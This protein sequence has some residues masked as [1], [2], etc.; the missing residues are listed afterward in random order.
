MAGPRLTKDGCS[1]LPSVARERLSGLEIMQKQ[2]FTGII[3]EKTEEHEKDGET[4]AL[5]DRK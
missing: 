3:T 5:S 1:S 4:Q 2:G